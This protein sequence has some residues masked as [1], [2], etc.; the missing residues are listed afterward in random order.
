MS[1]LRKALEA[2]LENETEVAP[3][4]LGVDLIFERL[5]FPLPKD[6]DF[7][8]LVHKSLA[9][10]LFQPEYSQRALR[11]ACYTHRIDFDSFFKSFQQQ[12]ILSVGIYDAKIQAFMTNPCRE[13]LSMPDP[14][15][16]LSRNGYTLAHVA[17]SCGSWKA[18]D[19]LYREFNA[20]LNVKDDHGVTPIWLACRYSHAD[21]LEWLINHGVKIDTTGWWGK[22]PFMFLPNFQENEYAKLAA[23]LCK[24]GAD[25]NYV[26]A[27]I[28]ESYLLN[29]L[30]CAA[31]DMDLLIVQ[32]RT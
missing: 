5:G 15:G 23:A 25:I 10:D 28:S 18:L 19:L 24:G 8:K 11:R 4:V 31:V 29:V 21:T 3:W 2:E 9:T 7:E 20:D 26:V 14:H 1:W 22:S 17:A 16:K 12:G 27:S 13:S 6:I 32:S 30:S